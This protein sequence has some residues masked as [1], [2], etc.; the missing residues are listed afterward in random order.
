MDFRLMHRAAA[1][2]TQCRLRAYVSGRYFSNRLG[3]SG[4]STITLRLQGEYYSI[5]EHE[6]FMIYGVNSL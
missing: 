4:V 5:D 6:F 3:H 2:R 1:P